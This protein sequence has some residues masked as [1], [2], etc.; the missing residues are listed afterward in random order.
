MSKQNLEIYCVTN[1]VITHIE[2]D[3]L[4]FA[5]VG[6]ESFP[7]YYVLSNDKINI[8]DK[9][10]F[11]SELTFHYWYWKNQ[12]DLNN[13]NW[14]GFC[15]RRRF[16]IKT[17]SEGKLINKDNINLHILAKAEESWKHYDSIICKPIKVNPVKKIKILKRGLK[18]F[19]RD[20]SILFNQSKQTLL[21]HFD[22][23][24]GYGN[25]EKA[26]ELLDSKNK[27]DFYEYVKKNTKFNPHIMYISKSNILDSWFK[28]LFSW[29]EKCETI[30]DK[31]NLSNYDTSRLLAYLAERYSSF[32]FK[33]YS[34]FKEQPW[35]FIDPEK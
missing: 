12:L 16:W 18:S 23:H 7:S 10:K 1:K 19:L 30:F 34:N 8:F 4:V 28:S 24:H 21:L 5:G 15:Q 33:K 31:N 35:I 6:N 13:M 29:L 9:E 2:K 14:I 27:Y 32:W 26:I 25:L 17:E 22:M 20:P 11:Y 3:K